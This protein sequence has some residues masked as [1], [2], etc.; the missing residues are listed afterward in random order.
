MIIPNSIFS[1][2]LFKSTQHQHQPNVD[3][4]V[5][6]NVWISSDS[7]LFCWLLKVMRQTSFCLDF[8]DQKI[9]SYKLLIQYVC[10]QYLLETTI[11][12]NTYLLFPFFLFFPYYF[13]YQG[14]SNVLQINVFLGKKM[15]INC[16]VRSSVF[17]CQMGTV[18]KQFFLF[19]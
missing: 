16:R 4:A 8:F 7:M 18:Q 10:T 6:I 9:D 13:Y 5:R 15:I 17:F 11:Y 12:Q 19:R 1:H 3:I 2:V 14:C